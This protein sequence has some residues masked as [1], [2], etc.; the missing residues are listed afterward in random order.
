LA[1]GSQDGDPGYVPEP[2]GLHDLRA[3]HPLGG[4]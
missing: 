4:A 1:A 3:A 2:D